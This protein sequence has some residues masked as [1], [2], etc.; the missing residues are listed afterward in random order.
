MAV[1]TAL[2]FRTCIDPITVIFAH[3]MPWIL[4]IH[5]PEWKAGGRAFF[6]FL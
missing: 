3:L 2:N 5:F 4:A 6:K 1:N